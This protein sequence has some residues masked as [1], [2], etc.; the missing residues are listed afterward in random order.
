MAITT[1]EATAFRNLAR[2]E[3]ELSEGINFFMGQNASGKTAFLEAVYYLGRAKS[4]R[5][6]ET[7]P[8]IQEE[9]ESFQIF[10]QLG[11]PHY[12]RIGIERSSRHIN[13]HRNGQPIK[14]LSLLAEAMPVLFISTENQRIFQD[15]PAFRRSTLDWGLFHLYP[16]YAENCRRYFRALSN[17]NSALRKNPEPALIAAWHPELA[18]QAA[19]ITRYRQEHF[20]AI[21]AQMERAYCE[22]LDDFDFSGAYLSGWREE[23]SLKDQLERQMEGDIRYGQTRIGSHRDDFRIEVG[24]KEASVVLSRGQQ[25]RFNIAFVLAQ[26]D[27]ISQVRQRSVITLIDDLSSEL[28]HAGW[29]SIINLLENST[30]Q[31]LITLIESELPQSTHLSGKMFHVEHGQINQRRE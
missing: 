5:C 23:E 8:L 19:L 26:K 31:Y 12:T 24:K 15:G 4:F 17:R 16:S 9:K 28:D 30:D 18:E 2:I 22:L 29:M 1:F 7:A 6:R 21:L 14:T 10:A 3:L 13:V 11:A 20:N 25:K 27:L